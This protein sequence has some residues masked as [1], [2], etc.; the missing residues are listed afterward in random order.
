[1]IVKNEGGD[2][3]QLFL[4]Q[5]EDML[6]SG[7]WNEASETSKE[8]QQQH[9]RVRSDLKETTTKHSRFASSFARK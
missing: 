5:E 3:G 2:D 8:G 4:K 7:I 1:M 9:S 6:D